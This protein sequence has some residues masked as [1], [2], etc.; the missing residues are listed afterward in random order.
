VSEIEDLAKGYSYMIEYDDGTE[1]VHLYFTN[2]LD[3]DNPSF[4]RF[5]PLYELGKGVERKVVDESVI[6]PYAR[7]I[8]IVK[9]LEPDV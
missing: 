7:V 3:M 6:I 5:D 8:R 4:L 1:F 9:R 2:G